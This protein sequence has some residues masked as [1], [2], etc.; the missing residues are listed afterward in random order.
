MMD[1]PTLE[2][3]SYTTVMV[4]RVPIPNDLHTFSK[5]PTMDID[6]DPSF[7]SVI[8]IRDFPSE[9]LQINISEVRQDGP[10]DGPSYT[11]DGPS[12]S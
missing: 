7:L 3:A 6:D 4:V 12:Y 2:G 1:N 11:H 8:T 9:G 5:C 10:H